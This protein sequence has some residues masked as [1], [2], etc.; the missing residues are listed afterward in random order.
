[1]IKVRYNEVW[2]GISLIQTKKE[3][4]WAVANNNQEIAK[5]GSE[6]RLIDKEIIELIEVFDKI[7]AKEV[8]KK[9]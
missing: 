3:D 6:L 4:I 7:R 8:I 5:N 1:M 9:L 2:G